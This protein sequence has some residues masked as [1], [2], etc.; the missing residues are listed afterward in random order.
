M[1]TQT[2]PSAKVRAP[3]S[4]ERVMRAAIALADASGIESL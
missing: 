4:R 2:D 1:A 3:L